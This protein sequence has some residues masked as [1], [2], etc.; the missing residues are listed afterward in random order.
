MAGQFVHSHLPAYGLGHRDPRRP[1]VTAGIGSGLP[2]FVGELGGTRT[3]DG[4]RIY[5]A[6]AR[7]GDLLVRAYTGVERGGETDRSYLK[8]SRSGVGSRSYSGDRQHG[9]PGRGYSGDRQYDD[10]ERDGP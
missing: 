6:L 1:H 7:E 3:Y 5:T 9:S 10:E 8:G 2:V 4:D